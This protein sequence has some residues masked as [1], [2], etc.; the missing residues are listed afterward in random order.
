MA[1]Q[2]A[3]V[4]PTETAMSAPSPP[5]KPART[6]APAVAWRPSRRALLMI[7]TA[8]AAGLLLFL[9]LWW[10]QRNSNDFF[11][12]P[13]ASGGIEGQEFEPLPAPL[14]AGGDDGS[15]SGMGRDDPDAGTL[16]DIADLPPP[17]P[18]PPVPPPVAE[19]PPEAMQGSASPPVPISSPAPRYPPAALRRGESGSVLLRVHV[20][21]AG[22]PVAVDIVESSGSRLLDRAASDALRRWRFRPA[23]RGGQPVSGQVQV[24]ISFNAAG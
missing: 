5:P 19:I 17:V 2:N 15:F 10:D 16:P 23:Q 1:C 14:P 7:A 18:L 4:I 24:P 21:A 20:D 13:A 6:P 12:A 11:K 3:R 9:L 8:F 22:M